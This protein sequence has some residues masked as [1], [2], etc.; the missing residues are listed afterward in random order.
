M[1]RLP[2]FE[3]E[4]RSR[5]S[6]SGATY[7]APDRSFTHS[8]HYLVH[9]GD[10]LTIICSSILR[11]LIAPNSGVRVKPELR[12]RT[13]RSGATYWAPDRSFTHCVRRCPRAGIHAKRPSGPAPRA[14]LP[15]SRC[16]ATSKHCLVHLGDS[17]TII[18]SSIFHQL[19]DASF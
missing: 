18:C 17:L 4:L 12:S 14:A 15:S 6:R 5:T 2:T 8:K 9:L 10:S 7:W 19:I 11:Q 1:H 3:P 16:R 13:S